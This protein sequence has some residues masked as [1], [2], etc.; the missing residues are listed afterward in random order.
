MSKCCPLCPRK[1][2]NSGHRGRSALCQSRPDALQP[3]S[4]AIRSPGA[5]LEAVR[6]RGERHSLMNAHAFELDNELRQVGIISHR[7]TW[8]K[9][10]PCPSFE[11]IGIAALR[12]PNAIKE[13]EDV[14]VCGFEFAGVHRGHR[15]RSP[16]SHGGVLAHCAARYRIGADQSAGIAS[17]LQPVSGPMS[18]LGHD[19][20][21]RS[22]PH[23]H[24][25]PLRPESGQIDHRVGCPLS[26]KSGH[27]H[28]SK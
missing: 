3:K 28:C 27:S 17:I 8:L 23:A 19:R 16:A 5:K 20:P 22:T 25:R 12:D 1:R 10:Y 2:T 24:A 13:H 21:R 6:W 7:V 4:T 14:V 11:R 18:A 9:R 26:A 15:S